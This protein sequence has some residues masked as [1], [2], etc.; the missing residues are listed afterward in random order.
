MKKFT[1]LRWAIMPVLFF[2]L[3]GCDD[4]MIEEP[5]TPQG[6]GGGNIEMPLTDIQIALPENSK[7]SPADLS[8]LSSLESFEVAADGTSQAVL[9]VDGMGWAGAFDSEDH[10]IFLGYITEDT[11]ELSVRSTAIAAVAISMGTILLPADVQL[12]F[13]EESAN[14]PGLDAFIEKLTEIYNANTSPLE[15]EAF[16]TAVHEYTEELL[17]DGPTIDANAKQIK[18]DHQDIRSGIQLEEKSSLSLSVINNYRRRA[19]AFAYKMSTTSSSGNAK[20]NILI[21]DIK[22]DNA[23][24][25]QDVQVKTTK[26]FIQV[27]GTAADI[28]SGTGI[29]FARTESENINFELGEDDKEAQ[30]KVRVVGPS[31]EFR[32][33]EKLTQT[34]LDKLIELQEETLVFDIALPVFALI[35]S[36]ADALKIP[37]KDLGIVTISENHLNRYRNAMLA[38]TASLSSVQDAA[39]KG[40]LQGMVREFIWSLYN[41]TVGDFENVMKVL[42]E[43]FVDYSKES[44]KTNY[45]VNNSKELTK[46]IEKSQVVLKV[47]DLLLLGNDILIRQGGAWAF[48]SYL[49][50]WD[51]KAI[52]SDVT[53]VLKDPMALPGISADMEATVKDLELAD[54]ETLEYRWKTSG[55]FGVLKDEVGHEGTSFTSSSKEVKYIV[56]ADDD[57]ITEESFDDLSVEVYLKKGQTSTLLNSD[58]EQIQIR[59]HGIVLKPNGITMHGNTTVNMF[60]ARNDGSSVIPENSAYDYRVTWTTSGHFGYFVGGKTSL[61]TINET[62]V[63]YKCLNKLVRNASETFTARIYTKKKTE[64]DYQL[65]EQV[66]ATIHIDNNPEELIYYVPIDVTGELIESGIWCNWGV[67]N[68]WRWNP[69]VAQA[70]MPAGY[71]VARYTMKVEEYSYWNSCRVSKTWYPGNEATDLVDFEEENGDITRNYELLCWRNSAS[72]PGYGDCSQAQQSFEERKAFWGSM[73]GYAKVTVY[74]KKKS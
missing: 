43:D 57:Q 5:P 14:L 30:Y 18:I 66:E 52:Q 63:E 72:G 44:G 70:D 35:I 20:P 42:L 69:S 17:S 12:R 23:A 13:L 61:S 34:E 32:N 29:G 48:A 47:V 27:T 59:T 55:K 58:T 53:L 56:T 46:G 25:S 26:E 8:V 37:N 40:D 68:V 41:N 65:L 3:P 9:N 62:E 19:H 15:S 74:L 31:F 50:E 33:I 73:K 21:Q 67:S 11:K 36:N 45:F 22:G 1:F 51:V 24:P 2:V 6:P 71:E 64:S 4:D 54:G 10:L 28:A 38:F 49:E 7:I 39:K 16:V 60:L